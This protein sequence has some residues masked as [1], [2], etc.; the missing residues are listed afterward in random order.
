[1]A[2]RPSDR[3][4]N[5]SNGSKW[6]RPEKRR[7]IYARDGRACVY[8]GR[9]A[10]LLCL[11]HVRPRARGGTND[12]RNLVTACVPCNSSR[13]DLPLRAWCIARG[14]DAHAVRARIRLVTRRALRG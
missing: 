3:G 9:L 1:M 13:R 8:C 12:A 10:P 14:I 2:R 4:S 6:I 7:A 5:G 11:D